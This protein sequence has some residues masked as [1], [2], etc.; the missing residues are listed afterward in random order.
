LAKG[1][2]GHACEARAALGVAR[3]V[4]LLPLAG[5]W[6]SAGGA[7]GRGGEALLTRT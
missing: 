6:A 7:P 1:Q 2:A 4:H 3:A 5:R